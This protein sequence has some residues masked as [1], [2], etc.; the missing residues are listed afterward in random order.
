MLMT[1]AVRHLPLSDHIVVLGADGKVAEQGSFDDLRVQHGFVN[2]I[3][4]KPDLLQSNADNVKQTGSSSQAPS[5]P[6]PK[7]PRGPAA[8]D[9]DDLSRRIGDTAVYK[10]YLRAI[11]WRIALVNGTGALIYML[12]SIFPRE[13]L[14]S[15]R[16]ANVNTFSGLWLSWYADGTISS[17]PLF[18]VIYV[19]A[20]L[21]SLCAIYIVLS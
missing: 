16:I 9:A 15:F 17:L 14:R 3:I 13:P 1:F 21:V 19:V 20:A 12:S 8:S 4:L 18:A 5:L 6:V 10:Y 2:K 7:A 11:G